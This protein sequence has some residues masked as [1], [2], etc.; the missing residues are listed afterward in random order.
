MDYDKLIERL[1]KASADGS[2]NTL[3]DYAHKAATSIETLRG[4]LARV[5]AERDAAVDDLETIMLAGGQNTDTCMY[6]KNAQCYGRGGSQLCSPQWRDP[7][8]EN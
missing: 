6:C 7:R 5:T 1:K 8:K 2:W 3:A 4:D